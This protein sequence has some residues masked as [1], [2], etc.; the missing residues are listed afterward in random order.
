MVNNKPILIFLT[1]SILLIVGMAYWLTADSTNP[2][3]ILNKQ[4]EKT[5]EAPL[6]PEENDISN[7]SNT[8]Q[9]NATA[10]MKTNL[11]T[12]TLELF[13]EDMPVTTGNFIKLAETGFYNDVKFH[14]V[15]NGFMVQGGDPS[16]KSDNQAV[17]GTGG[18]GYTIKDEFVEGELLTNTRGTI[19]MANT[20]QPNSGGSQFFI[21]LGDNS[22]LDFDKPPFS[23]K[24]PVFGR[25]ID[26]MDVVD[27]IANVETNPGDLPLE[28]VII[29]S[30]VI[31]TEGE[32]STE[33][34]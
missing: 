1:G 5:L 10:I 29:E 9:M 25:V 28:P 3:K 26:G 30:V 16:T 22:N 13:T 17:Y 8:N 20:G 33:G 7:P 31:S 2:E 32:G 21:N 34:E 4:A 27:A 24:H 23:S 14:R 6:T 15:I 12:I 18:P 11:G 19:A